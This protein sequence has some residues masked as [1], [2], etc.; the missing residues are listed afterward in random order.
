MASLLTSLKG[1]AVI[2]FIVAGQWMQ[3]EHWAMPFGAIGSVVAWYRIGQMIAYIATKLLHRDP[4]RVH[5]TIAP[6]GPA[7]VHVD[8]R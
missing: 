5:A 7:T 2:C 3:S 1:A 4:P 6:T 8:R